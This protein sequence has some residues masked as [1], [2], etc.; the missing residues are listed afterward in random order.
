MDENGSLESKNKR[1]SERS[2]KEKNTK[3]NEDTTNGEFN[4]SLLWNHHNSTSN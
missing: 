2:L 1:Q 4:F 3:K